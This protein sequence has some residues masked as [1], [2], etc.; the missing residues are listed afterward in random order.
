MV[1]QSTLTITGP[2]QIYVDGNAKFA[3]GGVVNVS[4]NPRN[5]TIYGAGHEFK[6]AGGSGFYGA[7]VAPESDVTLLGNAEYYGVLVGR[8]LD[9]RGTSFL[10]VDEAVVADLFGGDGA[11]APVLVE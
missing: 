8:T 11:V 6:F 7:I 1:G 10:H 4:Q 9:M 5:L 2:T 3:G